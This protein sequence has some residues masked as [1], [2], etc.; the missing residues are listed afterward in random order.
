MKVN[1]VT[2]KSRRRFLAL[3]G[4]ASATLA[5]NGLPFALAA[6]NRT[7]IGIIGSG[8]V[9]GAIG[10][11]WVK[12]GHEV[13][14]SSRHIKHDRELAIKL[15]ANAYAGTPREAAA[16]GE[17]E[18]ISVPY[19]ALPDVRENV[20]DLVKGKVVIDTCNPFVWRDGELAAW[21]REKG[22]GLASL[23]LLPGARIVRAFNAISYVSMGRAHE[24]PGRF[25]MPIAS[26]DAGAVAIASPLIRDVGYEPVLVGGMEMGKY[27][28]P[29]TPLAGERTPEEI[30]EIAA[31][32]S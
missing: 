23:E 28:M 31:T 29:G 22:A 26:D 27:L 16:F 10:S 12:A 18:M 32:L 30:R 25:G 17:V 5:L 20:G 14:F 4:A 1:D 11:V 9:G 2:K 3:V 15:G 24:Q 19:H 21:A 13:M 6:T 8:K 7:K